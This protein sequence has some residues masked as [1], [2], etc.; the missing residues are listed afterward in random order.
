MNSVWSLD[1]LYKGYD[2]PNFI[3]DLNKV[4]LSI[5]ELNSFVSILDNNEASNNLLKAIEIL[6]EQ[7]KLFTKL[8]AFFLIL[9]YNV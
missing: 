6:E 7:E 8:F 1:K 5:N 4:D 9:F 2:D 3:E